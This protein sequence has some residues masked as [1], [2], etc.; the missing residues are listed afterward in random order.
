M[1]VIF[2][3]IGLVVGAA[4]GWLVSKSKYQQPLP[5]TKEQFDAAQAEISRVKIESAQFQEAMNRLER[6]LDEAKTFL[7]TERA[8]SLLMTSQLS[9]ALTE[10]KNLSARMEEQ[11][12][13][14]EQINVRLTTEFK[15]IANTVLEEKSRSFTEQNKTSLDSILNP[16]KERIEEFKKQVETT[17]EKESRDTLSLKDEVRRLAEQNI[18]ISDEANNLTRALKGDTKTQGNWGEFILE[19]ILE[20]SGLEKDREY[21]LQVSTKNVDGDTIRPDVVVFLP[22]NKHI[23]IDSKVSL[24]A[25]EALV[26]AENDEEREQFKKEHIASLRSHLKLLGDKN[27]QTAESLNS[28]ELVL[29]FVPIEASFGIAVQADRE[30]F[31]VAWDKKIVIVSPSTLLA[32]LVTISSIWK[33][34]KQTKNAIDIAQRGGALYDKFVGFIEDMKDVGKQLDKSKDVYKDAMSKLYEGKGNIVRS[35]ETLKTLGAKTTK[36]IDQNLIERADID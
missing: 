24:T 1:D 32:T 13:E 4:A 5:F 35:V 30:L 16:L 34:E 11:K 33:Q 21:K 18:R 2:L 28:P 3:V 26:N 36:S 12:K 17:Y 9:E 6:S 10:N 14:L 20:R 8:K 19:K 7:E 25:Y 29:M 15:N 22:D 31:S 23:I 27:Y